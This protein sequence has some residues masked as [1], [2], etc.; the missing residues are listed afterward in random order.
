MAEN[1]RQLLSQQ[2]A[3]TTTKKD[4]KFAT[5]FGPHQFSLTDEN[6]PFV[7]DPKDPEKIIE[8]TDHS[9]AIQDFIVIKPSEYAIVYNPT[10]QYSEAYPNGQYKTGQSVEMPEL[11]YG[12]K[13]VVVSGSFPLWPYQRVELRK[14]H[15]LSTDQYLVAVVE[16]TKVDKEAPFYKLLCKCAAIKTTVV[17]E[18]VESVD[19]DGKELAKTENIKETIDT[20]SGSEDSS[21]K[22]MVKLYEDEKFVFVL[23]Q[24][25]VIPGNLTPTFIPPTGVEIVKDNGTQDSFIRQTV[26]LGPTDFCRVINEDG[27]I[28]NHKGPGRIFPGP[29]DKFETRGSHD[30]IYKA[31]HLRTDRGILLRIITDEVNKEHLVK[32]LPEGCEK[33]LERNKYFKGDEVFI[34]NIDAYLVPTNSFEVTHPTTREPHLGNDHEGVFVE[35]I[36]VDQESGVYVANVDTGNVELIRG[37]TKLLLDPRKQIHEKRR[38]PGKL[39]NLMIGEVEPHK[40]VDSGRM[41]ETPWALSVQVPNN[42]AVL[43]TGGENRRVVEGPCIELLEYRETLEVLTLSKGRPKKEN[44]ILETCRLR[45]EGLQVTD[46]VALTAAD[47][48]V[49]KVEVLYGLEFTAENDDEK[50]RWFDHKNYV[51]LLCSNLRSR[52]QA[53]ARKLSIDDLQARTAD[54]MRD[55]VLGEK[56]EDG[57]RR[58]FCEHNIRINEVDV[59]DHRIEDREIAELLKE[60][61][62]EIV[63]QQFKDRA[64]QARLDSS[65]RQFEINRQLAEL[66][67]KNVELKSETEVITRKLNN[68]AEVELAELTEEKKQKIN[69]VNLRVEKEIKKANAEYV[70]EIDRVQ[71]ELESTKLAFDTESEQEKAKLEVLRVE[72][73]TDHSVLQATYNTKLEEMDIELEEKKIEAGVRV[74]GLRR[75]I[76][77]ANVELGAKKIELEAMG[78]KQLLELELALAAQKVDAFVQETRAQTDGLANIQTAFASGIAAELR[79]LSDAHLTVEVAKALGPALAFEDGVNVEQLL[80][81]V[82]GSPLVTAALKSLGSKVDGFLQ[83]P[84]PVQPKPLPGKVDVVIREGVSDLLRGRDSDD[85]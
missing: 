46:E 58:G 7:P 77:E 72:L 79:R 29:Y 22:E 45:V 6:V 50:E 81:K 13:R 61:N 30:R 40:K 67:K 26:V 4:G 78:K 69:E 37:E 74:D 25:I 2:Y 11:L 19:Q 41:V 20:P 65:L 63:L 56:K 28:T 70:K 31:Y 49:I 76:E 66:Q 68:K 38:V 3:W 14:I 48:Q 80:A 5:F 53:A 57:P 62:R 1:K 39:W 12:G 54:F 82:S 43:V 16:S 47:D 75:Q 44:D 52:L 55:T 73:A 42:E 64:E 8:A 83:S 33:Q 85:D 59:L 10:E 18:S 51:W 35:A 36:G 60:T 17:D 24:R 21:N 84:L 27:K 15:E 34:K 9:R 32:Q 23:G 71:R